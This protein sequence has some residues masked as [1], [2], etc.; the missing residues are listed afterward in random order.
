MNHGA[1]KGC[2]SIRC[3][4]C[5]FWLVSRYVC[6]VAKNTNRKRSVANTSF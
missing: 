3:I 2:N 5:S 1:V 6:F 4:Y